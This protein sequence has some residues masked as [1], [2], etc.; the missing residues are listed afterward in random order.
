MKSASCGSVYPAYHAIAVADGRIK[1]TFVAWLKAPP[2][3]PDSTETWLVGF[4]ILQDLF[5]AVV[6]VEY[7]ATEYETISSKILAKPAIFD[8]QTATAGVKRRTP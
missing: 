5:F 7:A 3:A 6:M 2:K 1:D 4:R 8:Y